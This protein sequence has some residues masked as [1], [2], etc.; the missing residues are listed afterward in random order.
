MYTEDVKI[1]KVN[2]DNWYACCE[3]NVADEQRGFIEPNAVSSPN[4]SSKLR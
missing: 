4:Q 2:E 1:V 3:L